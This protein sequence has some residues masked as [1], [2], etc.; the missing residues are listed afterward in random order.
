[1]DDVTAM[2]SRK[3]VEALLLLIYQ[4]KVH[5]SEVQ[6]FTAEEWNNHVEERTKQHGRDVKHWY[7]TTKSDVNRE[8][9]LFGGKKNMFAELF[10]PDGAATQEMLGDRSKRAKEAHE[11]K[12]RPVDREQTASTTK[13]RSFDVSSSAVSSNNAGLAGMAAVTNITSYTTNNQGASFGAGSVNTGQGT[14]SGTN[15]SIGG[16]QLRGAIQEALMPF[17]AAIQTVYVWATSIDMPE[18]Y[19]KWF[20]SFFSFVSVDFT[21]AFPDITGIVTP[22]LQVSIGLTALA[23]VMYCLLEDD[24]C[25]TSALARY[26]WRRDA[27]AHSSAFAGKKIGEMT[28]RG[29]SPGSTLNTSTGSPPGFPDLEENLMD[30]STRMMATATTAV[31]AISLKDREKKYQLELG[32]ADIT[33]TDPGSPKLPPQLYEALQE[34]INVRPVNKEC[35]ATALPVRESRTIDLFT[36]A[37]SDPNPDDKIDYSGWE[38]VE[39]AT[40]A[41]LVLSVQRRRDLTEEELKAEHHDKFPIM[42]T[43]SLHATTQEEFEESKRSYNN[44]RTKGRKFQNV[45]GVTSSI[46]TTNADESTNKNPYNDADKG[47]YKSETAPTFAPFTQWWKVPKAGVR[48]H[49]HPERYLTPLTQTD[50]WPYFNRPSC[51][52]SINGNRCGRE[53][54]D[55]F[56]CG[57]VHTFPDGTSEMCMFALCEEHNRG[58][59][60]DLVKTMIWSTI[61]MLRS[62]G[63]MWILCVLSVLAVNAAYMPFMK[64]ALMI[65]GCHPFYQCEFEYCWSYVDQKFAIAAYFSI[66]VIVFLGAGF[67][68][69]F[70]LILRKRRRMIYDWT[71]GEEYKG[72]YSTDKGALQLREWARFV[73]TEPS[74]LAS[75]YKKLDANWIYFPP[76]MILLKFF[77]LLPAVFIEPRTFSQRLW[78]AIV[79]LVITLFVFGTKVYLSPILMLTLRVAEIHQLAILGLQNIDLVLLN[80]QNE[81]LGAYMIAVTIAY[82]A[83]SFVVFF[84]TT[85]W[86]HFSKKWRT[87]WHTIRLHRHGLESSAA[88]SLYLDPSVRQ[89]LPEDPLKSQPVCPPTTFGGPIPM[90]L[91]P[92]TA[93]ARQKFNK[94][95]NLLIAS[96]RG[97]RSINYSALAV[98]TGPGNKLDSQPSPSKEVAMVDQPPVDICESS[99]IVADGSTHVAKPFDQGANGGHGLEKVQTVDAFQQAIANANDD[100]DDDGADYEYE[101][102]PHEGAREAA[103]GSEEVEMAEL[104]PVGGAAI[105]PADHH[106]EANQVHLDEDDEVQTFSPLHG[107]IKKR[108][109]APDEPTVEDI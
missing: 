96:K 21:M 49:V 68:L 105:P 97:G 71:I 80:D 108:S 82:I 98:D 83:F 92:V 7:G 37:L 101:V 4:H 89:P 17:F 1:M 6:H 42:A 66:V 94:V 18:K 63:A 50:V 57:K 13:A 14:M 60:M 27:V 76:L 34:T 70:F 43:P 55:V 73:L 78:C 5:S 102:T 79:E 69:A 31:M 20:E 28:L 32:K 9:E 107:G 47:L 19:D 56:S 93:V 53:Y 103:G 40:D 99:T 30:S 54:G 33:F 59:I 67:P 104:R 77:T 3:P 25:F 36:G 41:N 91:P 24:R 35:V 106:V 109:A 16:A 39:I 15:G 8:V 10:G 23:F 58:S 84:I 86:P 26:V 75:Q 61:R 22:I 52:L 81:S 44:N 48:C 88:I 62:N 64:T 46:S 65:V 74:A 90:L 38:Q 45:P 85:I 87:Y 51:C 2:V 29:N 72:F 95:V 11:K 100:E 12:S